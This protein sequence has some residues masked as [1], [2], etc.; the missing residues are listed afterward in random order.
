MPELVVGWWWA[1]PVGALTMLPIIL[2]QGWDTLASGARARRPTG[3]VPL[4]ALGDKA[5]VDALVRFDTVDC[6]CANETQHEATR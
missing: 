3:L 5:L 1:D 6:I 4:E 2:W